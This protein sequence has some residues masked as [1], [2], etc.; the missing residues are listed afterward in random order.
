MN[1]RKITAFILSA[2]FVALT[3][4]S[5]GNA[6]TP[7]KKN[8]KA[9]D[10]SPETIELLSDDEKTAMQDVTAITGATDKSGKVVDNKGITDKM[11]HKIYSTGQKD[12]LGRLI[13]TTG[14]KDSKGNILYTM[15]VL[16]SSG[17]LIYY[18][19]T[20]KDDGTITLKPTN[21]TP[22]YKSNDVPKAPQTAGKVTTSATVPYKD[23]AKKY[24]N[25]AQCKYTKYFGGSGTDTFKKVKATDDGG[26]VAVGETYSLDGDLKGTDA[27]WKSAHSAV[28]KYDADGKMLWK[29]VA[30]GNS[31]V[32][33][34]DVAVLEDGT[35]VAV[36]YTKATDAPAKRN[37]TVVSSAIYKLKKDGSLMWAYSFPSDSKDQGEYISAIA[38]TPDGGFIVGG[39]ALSSSGFFK[40]TEAKGSKAFLFKFDKNCNVK[41][42]KI[43]SGSK[44]NNFSAIAVTSGGDIY[45]TCVT[46]SVDGDFSAFQQRSKVG[47]NTILVKLDKNGKLDWSKSLEGSG[48]SE[49]TTITATSDGGCVVGGSFTISKKAGGIYTQNYGSRDGYLIRYSSKGDVYWSRIVG[50]SKSDLIREV[51]ATEYGFVVVGTTQSADYDFQGLKV[52]GNDDGF[53]VYLNN[54]GE[55]N[56]KILLDGS[57]DDSASGAT[58]IKSGDVVVCGW[59]K[60]KNNAFNGSGATDQYK[61]F[62]SKYVAEI[63]EAK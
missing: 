48:E 24:V 40:D 1:K 10:N 54:K 26:Y 17:N 46:T 31:D 42:R 56:E 63:K 2:V 7:G 20:Y 29:Y 3:F 62:V 21:E 47:A 36:G 55:V 11:G 41:W 50:G 22:D 23:E 39:K 57:L 53:I 49:Y 5:C 27:N 59:T 44:S 38:A 12:S 32:S 14:K 33:L 8:E 13:Y 28:V 6:S 51:V 35:I 16:D 9:V 37:S 34:S 25:E 18:T 43:L 45:A 52:G 15:N 19:G 58:V 30:G 4:T 61:A 60:S